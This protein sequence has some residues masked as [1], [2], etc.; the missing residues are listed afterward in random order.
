LE[1]VL[2]SL[3]S[4]VYALDGRLRL[5][6]CNAASQRF[7]RTH[8][9]LEFREPPQ[10]G[11]SLLDNVPD[12][13]QRLE[14]ERLFRM[15][16]TEGQPQQAQAMTPD[17]HHWLGRITPWRQGGQI[18]GVIYRVTDNTAFA[19]ARSQLMQMQKMETIGALAAGVAH[20]FNNLLLA[21]RGNAGLV[22]MDKSLPAEPR[23]RLRHIEQAATRA[24]DLSQQLLSYSRPAEEKI[25]VLDL[26]QIVRDTSELARRVVRSRVELQ[27]QIPPEPLKVRMDAT[28]ATQALLNLCVNARDAMPK[29]G[30]LTLANA[31]V[32]L[33]A[34]QAARVGRPPGDA[35]VCC[36]VS[37][38]GTGIPPEVLPRIFT[39]FFTTKEK[40]KGTGLG[41]AIV[42]S[43]VTAAGGFVE[44]ESAA[45][46]GTTFRVYLP[47][48]QGPLTPGQTEFRHRLQRGAGRVL[49]V[50]DLGLVLGL[51][52]D[53]LRQA[54]YD[55][56]T[57]HS[58]DAALEVLAAQR[59]PVDLVFTDYAMPGRNGWQLIQ[60]IAARWPGVK[61]LLASGYLDETERAEIDRAGVRV[62][63]KPYGMNEATSAIAQ[64]L[65]PRPEGAADTILSP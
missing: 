11:Q 37:D 17:G 16:L 30:R 9:W 45:G 52:E 49:V 39:P 25:A 31:A 58:A 21:V 35:F 14:L 32:A 42:H 41:L 19:E 12:A 24:S 61:L 62:L 4:A 29:G 40:G 7:P 51:A 3:E 56:L 8:G 27:L 64:L 22:L 23:E 13:G 26:N 43:V 33:T 50:D 63:N 10:A 36:S 65:G 57:A 38:T 59:E 18:R 1:S 47:Q 20:D 28:R 34:A 2:D 15:A 46:A 6:W 48:D 55:V 54:G 44:V 5:A 60:E 53:F